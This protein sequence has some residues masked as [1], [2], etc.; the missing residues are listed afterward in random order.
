MQSLLMT[1]LLIVEKSQLFLEKV[2]VMLCLS[3]LSVKKEV[4]QDTEKEEQDDEK[5]K[6][7]HRPS[8]V[9]D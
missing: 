6:L 5:P 4:F 9:Y 7:S 1:T 3:S 8:M 2:G